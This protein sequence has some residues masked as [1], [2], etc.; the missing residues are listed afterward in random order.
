M[1][2]FQPTVPH[3]SPRLDPR[4][5]RVSGGNESVLLAHCDDRD[6][7]GVS[8]KQ[9]RTLLCKRRTVHT[10]QTETSRTRRGTCG[11]GGGGT[12]R[13]ADGCG[14]GCPRP[15]VRLTGRKDVTGRHGASRLSSSCNVLLN[16][17]CICTGVGT[18]ERPGALNARNELAGRVRVP[19]RAVVSVWLLSDRRCLITADYRC[20]RRDV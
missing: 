7:Q 8:A 9:Q 18:D 4:L 15:A 14:P 10:G 20:R 2:P 6:R 11:E 3:R 12:N 16:G 17:N 5:G 19:L 1:E 13:S